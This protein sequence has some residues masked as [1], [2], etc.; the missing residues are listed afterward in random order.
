MSGGMNANAMKQWW[1]PAR[2]G[3]LSRV[4]A[5][6]V[7]AYVIINLANLAL[8]YVLPAERYQSLLFAMQT[9]FLFYTLAIIWVFAVRTAAKAWMGLLVVAV[10]LLLI[11]VFFYF[12]GGV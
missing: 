7:G 4:L 3:M 9:S 12:Q 6:S 5:A 8:A 10:P 11:D 1:T 2:L